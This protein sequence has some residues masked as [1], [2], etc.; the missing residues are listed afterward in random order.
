MPGD[1]DVLDVTGMVADIRRRRAAPGAPRTLLVAVSGINA[2]GK[3]VVAHRVANT[4]R[5]DGV[6]VAVVTPEPWQS[7]LEKIR[8]ADNPAEHYY[9]SAV[10]F[11]DLFR[12]LIDPLRETGTVRLSTHIE[13]KPEDWIEYHFDLERV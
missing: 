13:R 12:L 6:R 3:G 2:A 9:R 7:P 8:S 11:D 1:T 5:P 4:L 10:Q